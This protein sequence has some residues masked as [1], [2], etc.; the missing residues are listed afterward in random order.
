MSRSA[1][2]AETARSTPNL[3]LRRVLW[4]LAAVLGGAMLA[5]IFVAYL[6]PGFLLEVLNLRYCG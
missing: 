1:L 4:F 5:L 3:A 6:R 2:P